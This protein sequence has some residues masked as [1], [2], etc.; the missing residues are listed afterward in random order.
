MASSRET[1]LPEGDGLRSV[2][3]GCSGTRS[4][5]FRFSGTE[6]ARGRRAPSSHTATCS[7]PRSAGAMLSAWPSRAA[8]MGSSSSMLRGLPART[9]APS[10]AAARMAA[11]APSPLASG[12]PLRQSKERAPGRFAPLASKKASAAASAMRG[13]RSSGCSISPSC[14]WSV[15]ADHRSRARPRQSKPGPRLADV[16]GRRRSTFEGGNCGTQG[17]ISLTILSFGLRWHNARSG[18]YSP[19]GA[20]KRDNWGRGLVV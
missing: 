11:L 16:A 17:D 18:A 15:A 20:R 9:F 19:A 3:I 12:K 10:R 4:T 7:P 14:A 6:P 1:S 2:G 13:T 5:T 8:P